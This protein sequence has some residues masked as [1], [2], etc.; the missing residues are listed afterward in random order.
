MP[1]HSIEAAHERAALYTAGALSVAEQQEFE[2]HLKHGCD[3]CQAA[4]DSFAGVAA[5]LA[6]ST[7]PRR[8]RAALR[9]LVRESVARIAEEPVVTERDGVR[10]VRGGGLPW[11]SSGEGAPQIKRLNHDSQRGYR[12]VLVRMKPGD[13]YPRHRHADVEDVY[14][15]EGD[16]TLNGISMGPGDYCRA[17]PG[18]IHSELSTRHGCTFIVFASDRDEL[19]AG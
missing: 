8:P 18:S 9:E 14:L 7:T 1:S 16:L 11:E 19:I 13:T 17:E 10:F 3:T 4:V 5:M 2:D 12:S 6:Q 15:I